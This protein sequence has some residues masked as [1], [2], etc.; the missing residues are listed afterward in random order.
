MNGKH[1]RVA[2]AM[3]LI[4]AGLLAIGC[5]GSEPPRKMVVTGLVDA[6][7]IDVAS[8]VPGRVHEVLVREGDHVEAGQRLVAIESHEL[9]AKID[10]VT[11]LMD[12]S[13]A[14]LRLARSGVRVEE[15][16]AVKKQLEA[17]QSAA[18]TA[19]KMYERSKALLAEKAIAPAKWDEIE[20]RYQMAVDQLAMAQA[21]WDM[22][23]NGA[24]AE[25]IQALEALVRQSEGG[26]AEVAAYH[27]ETEQTAPLAGE[28]AK[29]VLHKGELAA[30]GYP[31]LTIVDL[32]DVWV[33]FAVR[34]DMLQKVQ[35]DAVIEVEVP[36]LGRTVPMKV[37]N[38]SVLGDFATWRA[39][40]EKDRFDLKSFEV[41]ARPVDPAPGLRPGMT[42]RFT[43][44]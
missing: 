13:K 2:R 39:T 27:K 17:A 5:K 33:T 14:K 11:A 4:S 38:V 1:V 30:T 22:V 6:T 26:L 35:K 42:A 25:E 24:R 18:D 32:S 20:L 19:R 3:T 15:K 12:A 28:V 44:S 40:S 36:A 8:K 7:E 34:E 43:E 10:Q 31:I 29:V 9:D 23:Q 37:F 21:K 41:K 16:A